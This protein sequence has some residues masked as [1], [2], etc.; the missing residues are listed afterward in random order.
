MT[1]F[2]HL[3]SNVILFVYAIFFWMITFGLLILKLWSCRAMM[4]TARRLLASVVLLF[5][6]YHDDSCTSM[7]HSL[8]LLLHANRKSITC[9]PNRTECVLDSNSIDDDLCVETYFKCTHTHTHIHT[10]TQFN[11]RNSVCV[12]HRHS[13]WMQQS[14]TLMWRVYFGRLLLVCPAGTVY[15]IHAVAVAVAISLRSVS[16]FSRYAA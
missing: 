3:C 11:H 10:L 2:D 13:S 15:K 12:W 5:A 1:N 7:S 9:Q 6:C 14:H 16:V 4:R 8:R